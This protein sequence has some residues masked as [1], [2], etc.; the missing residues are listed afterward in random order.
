MIKVLLIED[1]DDDL[2]IIEEILDPGRF[3]L[4]F[5]HDKRDGIEIAVRYLPNLILFHF[6]GN[7]DVAFLNLI[8]QNEITSCIPVIVIPATPTFKE[9]RMLMELGVEDYLPKHFIAGSLLKT[10]Y[11]RFEKLRKIKQKVN[12]QINSF[13]NIGRNSKNNDHLLVKIGKKL[14]LIKFSDIVCITALKEYSK[15]KTRDNLEVLV[16]KSMR[17]WVKMLPAKSFLRIHRAT[18]INLEYVDKISQTNNRT[19]SVSL[20]GVKDTFDFSYRYANVMRR[21]FPT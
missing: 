2:N 21:T 6:S 19:Y 14:K 1:K 15:I 9:Q 7:D 3:S 16:R 12:D 10:I 18:I 4:H 5:S 11:S 8:L 13:E 20:K 17:N